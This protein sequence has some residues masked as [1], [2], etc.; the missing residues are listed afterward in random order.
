VAAVIVTAG[1]TACRDR[2]ADPPA[3]ASAGSAR[4]Q[5]QR[6]AALRTAHVWTSPATP[7][8]AVDFSRNTPGSG[9]LDAASDIDCE[10]VLRPTRGTSAKFYCRL[11]DGDVVKVKY[12]ETNPEIPAEVAASRLLSA[13]GFYVD[14]M[15]LVNSVRCRGCPPFPAQALACIKAGGANAVCLQ[16]ASPAAVRTFEQVMIERPFDGRDIETPDTEG[17]AWFE[18]D[19]ID[20][21]AGGASR[22][23]VDALRLMAVLLAHWDNKSSNQRLVCPP[24][25]EGADGACRSPAAVLHDLGATFGPLK[26]DLSNWKRVPIWADAAS[27]RT[28]MKSLPYKGG[29]FADTQISEDGRLLA[30]KLL[31][32]LS[33]AQLNTLFEASRFG[34][35]PHVLA[36]AAQPQA[37]TDV[38]VAKVEEIASA[39]PCPVRGGT[40]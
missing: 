10:F 19:T 22:V 33:P 6:Q 27:C 28:T 12:G 11:A 3:P 34:S 29:T 21:K 36:A 23:E 24:G 13:L 4:A 18:L 1:L 2:D 31:R 25:A 35:F 40:H 5:Q 30:L 7:P 32:A 15:M 14:R 16:G 9:M 38:F 17:W 20:T 37:W 26:A 39:G 8:G